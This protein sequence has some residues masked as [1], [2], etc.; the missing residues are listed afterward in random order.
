[1]I[2]GRDEA[3]EDYGID[4][5]GDEWLQDFDRR[6]ELRIGRPGQA[7]GPCHEARERSRFIQAG[8]R[9]YIEGVHFVDIV[10]EDLLFE[11]LGIRGKTIAKRAERGGRRRADAAH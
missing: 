11:P 3:A 4:A 5:L 1:M 6:F 8:R 7:F 10:V 9:L 2:G